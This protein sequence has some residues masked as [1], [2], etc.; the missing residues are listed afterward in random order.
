MSENTKIC[1]LWLETDWETIL[2]EKLQ[3]LLRNSVYSRRK[4][5][6]RSFKIW[7]ISLKITHSFIVKYHVGRFSFLKWPLLF[8]WVMDQYLKWFWR[9]S[10]SVSLNLVSTK[11]GL[12]IGSHPPVWKPEGSGLL[13]EKWTITPWVG[14]HF[15]LQFFFPFL[16]TADF[17]PIR[18]LLKWIEHLRSMLSF[19]GLTDTILFCF[20]GCFRG[21]YRLWSS[22][23]D[24][25]SASKRTDL[26]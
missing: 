4:I 18:C 5:S 12:M 2:K 3:V 14:H 10:L 17:C 20:H 15:C 8:R 24:C 13:E 23:G 9:N 22:G 11:N 1:V 21:F 7:Y 19:V 6:I 25:V 16:S 26:K